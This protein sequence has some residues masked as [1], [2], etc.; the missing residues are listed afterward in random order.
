MTKTIKPFDA[1]SW[2]PIH[3]AVFDVI[4]PRLSPNGCKVLCV[5]IRQTW[6]LRGWLAH[7]EASDALQDPVAFVFASLRDRYQAHMPTKS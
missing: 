3:N 2:F 7:A 6:N 1:G 4:M 5:A